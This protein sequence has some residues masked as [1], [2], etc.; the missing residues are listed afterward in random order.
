MSILKLLAIFACLIAVIVFIAQNLK[1]TQRS[2]L[3]FSSVLLLSLALFFVSDYAESKLDKTKT[4]AIAAQTDSTKLKKDVKEQ[5]KQDALSNDDVLDADQQ[6]DVVIAT[7][8][9][10]LPTDTQDPQ[11]DATDDA[12]ADDTAVANAKIKVIP[13]TEDVNPKA[14]IADAGSN[15]DAVKV[16]EAVAF[17]AKASKKGEGGRPISTY[18]WDFGDGKKATG[19][20][21]K[22]AYDKAGNFVVT[23]TVTDAAG[24]SASATRLVNVSRPEGKIRYVNRKLEDYFG[25]GSADTLSGTFEKEYEESKT[26]LEVNANIVSKKDCT[27]TITAQIIGPQCHARQS[28]SLDDGGEG[29]T[30][31]KAICKGAMGTYTWS[32]IREASSPSCECVWTK[33]RVDGFES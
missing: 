12:N 5:P 7:A 9:E 15:I 2:T 19:R 32:V 30:S 33:V 22:H 4:T 24:L 11:V 14:P 31:V 18:T 20:D 21:V 10:N 26:H 23:L 28:K 13:D 16:K 25:S 1:K 6:Q 17:S 3:L 29:E 27:C 8:D